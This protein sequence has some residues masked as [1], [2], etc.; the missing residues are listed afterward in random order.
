MKD[1]FESL[2]RCFHITNTIL[3]SS[4]DRSSLNY[5][6]L[7]KISWLIEEICNRCKEMYNMGKIITI[8]E[9]MIK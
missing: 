5:D 3:G 2:N 9:M 6:K 7:A 8:D 4:H 1:R